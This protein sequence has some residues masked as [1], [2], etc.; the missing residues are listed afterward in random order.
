MMWD[1]FLV[2]SSFLDLHYEYSIQIRC[3]PHIDVKRGN[4]LRNLP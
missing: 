4:D 2:D 1:R 3:T